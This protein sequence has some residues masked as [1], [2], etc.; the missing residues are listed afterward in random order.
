MF[1]K[2]NKLH[3]INAPNTISGHYT[4]SEGN[5]IGLAELG[6]PQKSLGQQHLHIYHAS[7]HRS[8]HTTCLFAQNYARVLC[9]YI[10][11]C[12]FAWLSIYTI[13]S[14][15]MPSF[16]NKSLIWGKWHLNVS[17]PISS[18]CF[19]GVLQ[20]VQCF[21]QEACPP[22]QFWVHGTDVEFLNAVCAMSNWICVHMADRS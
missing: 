18:K 12:C 15:T 6:H 8:V 7:L 3:L 11:L 20:A 4:S 5:V 14:K 1:K 10:T 22:T 9:M 16:K 13:I 2:R 21:V 19:E 17:K